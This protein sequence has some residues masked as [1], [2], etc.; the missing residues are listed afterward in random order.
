M[1]SETAARFKKFF[2]VSRITALL[3]G[4]LALKAVLPEIRG[5]GLYLLFAVGILHMR[6][7][8]GGIRGKAPERR[9][10]GARTKSLR[11]RE[12]HRNPFL[13]EFQT[14]ILQIWSNL[15]LVLHQILR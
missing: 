8:V 14:Q 10:F 7:T 2:S 3:F 9:H 15:F 6:S 13:A 12:P 4:N 1:T 5:D 11:I